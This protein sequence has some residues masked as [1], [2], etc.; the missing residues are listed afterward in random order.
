M[1]KGLKAKSMKR[2][3]TEKRDKLDNWETKNVEALYEKMK[4]V[5]E[6]P[7]PAPTIRT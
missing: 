5:I 1:G 3:R 2:K 6:A 4:Q 7:V